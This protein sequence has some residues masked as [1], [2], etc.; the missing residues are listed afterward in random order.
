[1]NFI[2]LLCAET[3]LSIEFV[4]NN[5][6]FWH[7]KTVNLGPNFLHF[8]HDIFSSKIRGGKAL[9]CFF[10]LQSK[11]GK[12]QGLLQAT[13]IQLLLKITQKRSPM[14][15]KSNKKSLKNKSSLRFNQSTK[16]VKTGNKFY[17]LPVKYVQKNDIWCSITRDLKT[18]K[19]KLDKKSKKENEKV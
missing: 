4:K 13:S 17:N 2:T 9:K 11:N 16:Y 1:M 14:Y 3:L 8:V 7:I 5:C 12:L 6:V 19:R 15:I 10:F 18:R